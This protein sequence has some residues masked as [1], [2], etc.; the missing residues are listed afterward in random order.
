M[1]FS[2][3]PST[4]PG[5]VH[6]SSTSSH[7]TTTADSSTFPASTAAYTSSPASEMSTT[8]SDTSGIA[9]ASNTA[10]S[11]S[12][13]GDGSSS[14][15]SGNKTTV[16]VLATLMSIVGALL[17]A[18][19]ILAIIRCRRRRSTLFSRG[20]T[21][22]DDEEIETWKGNRVEKGLGDGAELTTTSPDSRHGHQK[23]ESVG[24][25]KKP[26]SVIVYNRR[27]EERFQPRSPPVSAGLHGKMS[28]EGRKMS[29]D[30]ELPFTP[31]QARAPN[32]R[33]GLTDET[34]PGDPSF[35]PSPKRQTS[36]L[37]KHPRQP[38][39]AHM[40]NKSSRSTIS[41]NNMYT[42]DGY[43]NNG[44]ESDADMAYRASHD[45]QRFHP[46]QSRALSGS[47]ITPRLSLTDE[48][49]ASGGLSPRP[50]VVRREDI[51]R[52]FG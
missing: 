28:F 15:D 50:L 14:S 25:T 5:D 35:I 2:N 38:R 31:I 26:P 51:G 10:S 11:S 48:W 36:R 8:P 21:P 18:G 52:A 4:F 6:S 32:A 33:E 49:P 23:H 47:P 34:I 3:R 20:I 46:H 16:I 27:S 19:A 24:S 30:K 17:I 43:H 22:I 12:A 37:S 7:L 42:G 13:N 39:Q 44:Y 9:S 1:S 45:Q 29:L 40:R 41:L